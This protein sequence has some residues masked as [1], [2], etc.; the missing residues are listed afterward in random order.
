[1]VGL[2]EVT[3][4]SAHLPYRGAEFM[5]CEELE[6]LSGGYTHSIEAFQAKW[7]TSH[8]ALGADLNVT[9][10]PMLDGLTSDRI[11]GNPNR[12]PARW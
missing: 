11:H 2:G 8:L 4:V 1:M 10:Q 9:L 5:K 7:E 12:A 3:V 6:E